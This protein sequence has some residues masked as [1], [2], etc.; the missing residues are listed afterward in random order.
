MDP[1]LPVDRQ[2]VADISYNDE[3]NMDG[4]TWEGLEH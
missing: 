2:N 4:E 1:N 3:D